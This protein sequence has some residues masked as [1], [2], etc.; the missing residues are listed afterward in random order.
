MRVLAY[1][2]D[3]GGVS[4]V[5]P[6][7][8]ELRRKGNEVVVYSKGIGEQKF[9]DCG[10]TAFSYDQ[11]EDDIPDLFEDQSYNYVL[12][13]TSTFDRTERDL[14]KESKK[15]GILSIAVMD[16]WLNYHVRFTD[17]VM[18]Q[19]I[20]HPYSIDVKP[21][22]LVVL[23]SSMFQ[24]FMGLGFKNDELLIAAHTRLFKMHE[25]SQQ[26]KAGKRKLQNGEVDELPLKVL[27]FGE[28]IES[29]YKNKDLFGFNEYD[30]L[31]FLIKA[32]SELSAELIIKPHPKQ[33]LDEEKVASIVQVS[34]I[35]YKISKKLNETE[36]KADIYTGTFTMALLEHIA[37][38]DRV[39]AIIPDRKADVFSVVAKRFTNQVA[40][41]EKD[42]IRLLQGSQPSDI[43]KLL[44]DKDPCQI[45]VDYMEA[46]NG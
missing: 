26:S 31:G 44:G 35:K 30:A 43:K 28:P 22:K 41:N 8:E 20:S 24:E 45:I 7:I 33:K 37:M 9:R 29:I 3:P 15:R 19:G 6:V 25:L 2:H 13:A 42:V 40:R 38:N 23:D 21:S 1:A 10:M 14:W 18:N 12:T 17:E 39:I 32:L 11:K 34:P 36:M 16:H 5:A 4:V 27:H 46:T